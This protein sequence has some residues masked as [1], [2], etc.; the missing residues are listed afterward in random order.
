MTTDDKQK[1][2]LFN[3]FFGT[4]YTLDDQQSMPDKPNL[5]VTQY[6]SNIEIVKTEV[7]NL[8]QKL[9]TEKSP[10][11][12]RIHP[13]VLKEC[14]LELAGPLTTL[15]QAS[16]M[17]GELPE[18]WKEAVVTPVFKKGSRSDVGNYR[19][20]SLTSICCKVMERIIRKRLIQHMLENKFLSENQHGFLQGRSCT[21][22]LLRVVDKLT[23]I[24]DQGGAVDMV[25]LDFAKAFDT[26]SHRRLLIK[27]E[28]Y[29]VRDEV[30]R[31]I[32]KFLV[33]RRQR[34]GVAG[35]FSEWAPVL[36]GI[37]QGSVLGPVLFVCYINDLP[38]AI[39]SIVYMYADDTKIFR[40]VD[41]EVDRAA[42]QNDLD[43]LSKW[44]EEWR[45][46]F[47]VTKCKV[48]HLGSNNE[49]RKLSML[50]GISRI[51]VQET[52]LEKDLGIWFNETLKPHDHI[53]QVVKKANQILGLIRRTF[54]HMDC[55]L[56]K[57]LFT[58]LVR[59][60]L[61]YGN[62]VWHPCYLRDIELIESVQHRATRMIPGMSKLS[63]EERLRKMDLPTLEYRRKRG[64]AIEAYKYLHGKY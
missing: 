34:V 30:L 44:A 35:S 61:E 60:H 46:R 52:T 64:D 48:M 38:E 6:L 8:L 63:Y 51:E 1:A 53:T 55:H 54:T 5:N 10:G 11:P 17:E 58:S 59:P 3:D 15:F 36:S 13:C 40:Q 4:M 2:E 57:M 41:K 23:E 37:T 27:L 7:L 9:Q 31:W 50:E 12:D 45:L 56:M 62:V 21:T 18:E 32:E 42:L 19:P 25:Y 22:Q 47:N 20:V 39:T 16:L 26:V 24:M 49:K 43:S 33:G 29:G 28:G 14:A